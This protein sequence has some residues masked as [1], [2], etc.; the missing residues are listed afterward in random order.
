MHVYNNIWMIS[1]QNEKCFRQT[2]SQKSKHKLYVQ[3]YFS[4][5]RAI[6]EIR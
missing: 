2:L 1:S 3:K 6:Y 5:N 4:E